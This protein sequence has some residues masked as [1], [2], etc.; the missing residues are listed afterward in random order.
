MD[1]GKGRWTEDGRRE[2][3]RER[4]SSRR[5]REPKKNGEETGPST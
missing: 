1:D 2:E 4:K 3:E 5:E